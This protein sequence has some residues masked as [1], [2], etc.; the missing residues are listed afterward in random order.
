MSTIATSA[1][2]KRSYELAGITSPPRA[3]RTF[4]RSASVPRLRRSALSV[5]TRDEERAR[6]IDALARNEAESLSLHRQ[7]M[8]LENHETEHAHD[9]AIHDKHSDNEEKTSSALNA[10]IGSI[11]PSSF[12]YRTPKKVTGT[13][14]MAPVVQD[15]FSDCSGEAS[16][17][18]FGTSPRRLLWAPR[19][20]PTSPLLS[21]PPIQSTHAIS[22]LQDPTLTWVI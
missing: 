4:T 11:P 3:K 22:L 1:S 8:R 18:V 10:S 16:G 5:L 17:G 15:A 6:I 12:V 2:A 14:S 20:T 9:S 13:V 19:K 7:L 21:G